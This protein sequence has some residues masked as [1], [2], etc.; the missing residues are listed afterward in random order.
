[1]E[2]QQITTASKTH[3]H[4]SKELQQ[5]LGQVAQEL[6]AAAEIKGTANGLVDY[7]KLVK[8]V[9][10]EPPSPR[11]ESEPAEDEEAAASAAA[12]ADE[13]ADDNTA[14]SADDHASSLPF[15][16]DPFV[17]AY[18]AARVN[19]CPSG[20]YAAVFETLGFDAF[21]GDLSPAGTV[22]LAVAGPSS[23]E[24]RKAREEEAAAAA[25]KNDAAMAVFP[26]VLHKDAFLL[27]RALCKL[28]MKVY[29][30]HHTHHTL[31]EGT[32]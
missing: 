14:S 8:L 2:L 27:F 19:G 28:S 18:Q 30:T 21:K 26:S 31:D 9:L 5:K 25:A 29:H 13:A 16:S 3:H 10:N 24:M 7:A 15:P 4:V 11:R 17:A 1:M 6:E 20:M 23:P 22:A 32:A 12:E